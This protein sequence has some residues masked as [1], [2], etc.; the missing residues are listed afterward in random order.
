MNKRWIYHT[1]AI[2]VASAGL[3]A[4]YMNLEVVAADHHVKVVNELQDLKRKD[5]TLNSN[6]FNIR[7]GLTKHYDDL[8]KTN[9]ETESIIANLREGESRIAG[10]GNTDINQLVKQYEG[11]HVKRNVLIDR[12]KT[13]NS[14]LKN[15]V[16]YFPLI[17][18]EIVRRAPEYNASS[19]LVAS[20]ETLMK[21]LLSY[22]INSDKTVYDTVRADLQ[23]VTNLLPAAPAE[24]RPRMLE[25]MKHASIVLWHKREIDG[26][27]RQITSAESAAVADSLFHVYQIDHRNAEGRV[28]FYRAGLYMGISAVIC[29]IIFLFIGSFQ[30]RSRR[31]SSPAPQETA[32]A[33]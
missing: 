10:Y 22:Y 18:T 28:K 21:S 5:A 27:L 16:Y 23:N 8:V 33:H 30:N 13:R 4:L 31:R 11:L 14:T 15:G 25:M 32:L 6:V 26:L 7:S 29:Y 12:F 1:L 17:A 24:L 9:S 20:I 2:A 19:E 3:A